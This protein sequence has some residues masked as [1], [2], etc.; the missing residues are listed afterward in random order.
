MASFAEWLIDHGSDNPVAI[1][2]R[3][4]IAAPNAGPVLR[5]KSVSGVKRWFD[6]PEREWDDREA[7]E[8]ALGQLVASYTHDRGGRALESTERAEASEWQAW[9]SGVLEGLSQRLGGI[10]AALTW[11]V[12][13][14][15]AQTALSQAQ[16]DS[17]SAQDYRDWAGGDQTRSEAAALG[18]V[19]PA[20]GRSSAANPPVDNEV[21]AQP[22]RS[23]VPGYENVLPPGTK[24]GPAGYEGVPAQP[25]DLTTYDAAILPAPP[26]YPEVD[27]SQDQLKSTSDDHGRLAHAIAAEAARIQAGADGG[28]PGA[29]YDESAQVQEVAPQSYS[30]EQWRAWAMTSD[31]PDDQ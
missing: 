23:S 6:A 17:A 22:G 16:T 2:W 21:P 1:A 13:A 10:E 20:P 19:T 8:Q 31:I 14:M 18:L 25:M 29:Y 15:A 24:P 28:P 5:I 4:A 11:V 27:N 9:V 3:A 26:D 30:A 7:M 12:D